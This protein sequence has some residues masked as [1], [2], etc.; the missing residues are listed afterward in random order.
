MLSKDLFRII[1]KV[2]G[3]VLILDLFALISQLIPIIVY[4]TQP[5]YSEEVIWTSLST[6]FMLVIYCIGIFFLLFRTDS[7]ITLFKL[8]HGLE[9]E[10]IQLNIHRSSIIIIVILIIAGLLLV[11]EIPNILKQIFLYFQEKRLT[12]GQTTPSI[13][14]II[15]TLVKIIIAALLIGH[16]RTIV[17]Y[18]EYKRRS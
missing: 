7:L 2:F 3:L 4:M 6:F 12:K 13:I 11:R 1:L 15:V 5:D 16:S 14:P 8:D 10:N 18:I 17:N 9:T